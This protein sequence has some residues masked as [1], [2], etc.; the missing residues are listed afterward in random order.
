MI[1]EITV[2]IK[3]T[4]PLLMHAFPLEPIEAIG[5]KTPAEQAEYAAYR[6]P[7]TDELYIPG[8]AIQRALVGAATYSQGKGRA[9]LQKPAAACL[10]V[11]PDYVGLGVTDY[12]I[13]SRPVVVPATR[14]RIMRHRPRLDEWK[15]VFNLE[16][17]DVLLSEKQVREIVDN[18]CSRVG[19]LDFRPERK[20]PFGRSMVT[21]WKANGS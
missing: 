6:V 16:Y 17:D 12:A 3:G 20:G 21:S 9:T 2:A 7:A 14:G 18:M 15:V 8:V 5:K 1:K 4:S 11:S 19:L 13:D 10:L